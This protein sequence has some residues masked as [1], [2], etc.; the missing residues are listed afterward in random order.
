MK[1]ISR[2]AQETVSRGRVYWI[3]MALL[4]IVAGWSFSPAARGQAVNGGIVG[5]VTDSSG[6]V[7]PQARVTITNTA[8][9]VGQGGATDSNGYYS[10]PDLPPGS[11]KVAVAKQGFSTIVRSG[12]R[13]FVNSTVRVDVSLK[14]GEMTQ[15]VNVKSTIPLLQTD[16]AQTGGQLTSVQAT[17]LPLGTN[18]NFQNLLNLIPGSSGTAYNH[19]HFFNPQNSLNSE[20]NGTSSLTNNFQIEGVNDNERTGLLQVYIPPIEAIQEVNVTTSNYDA[21]QGTALGAVVNVIMESARTSST[22]PRMRSIT[23]KR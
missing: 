2:F 15:T 22:A 21:E 18:R 9:N 10:F 7:V 23:A 16:T 8:T 4:L 19:S 20:V 14:P 6:A 11:Y 1:K 13:L 17:Q 12:V 5:T 3:V